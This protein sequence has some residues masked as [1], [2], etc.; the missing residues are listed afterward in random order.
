MSEKN[1]KTVNEQYLEAMSKRT[2]AVQASGEVPSRYVYE[3]EGHTWVLTLPRSVMEQKKLI[4]ARNE[5]YA[6]DSYEA[7]DKMLRMMAQNARVDD[8]EVKLEQLDLGQIEVLKLAYLDG[9]LL[10][11][12]L[13][14]ENA[15]KKYMQ[16]AVQNLG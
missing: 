16:T 7:E 5:Y 3:H 9:L 2:E 12:S 15:L 4:H 6:T 14:G 10:P 13:G 8:R 1:E 11:L